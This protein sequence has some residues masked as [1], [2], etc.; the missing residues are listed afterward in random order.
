MGG[1]DRSIKLLF[2]VIAKA[3]NKQPLRTK[4]LYACGNLSEFQPEANGL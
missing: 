3:S 4:S 2:P 1:L